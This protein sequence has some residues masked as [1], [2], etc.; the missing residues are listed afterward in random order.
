[1]PVAKT[2][3][4]MP[5]QGKPF[6]E[7]KRMYVYVI[8]KTGAKKV[9]WYTEQEYARMYNNENT[10]VKDIM[11]FNACH[12][13]GFDTHGYITI[14]KGDQDYIKEWADEHRD[15]IRYNLTFL[16]YMPSRFDLPENIPANITPIRL[17]WSQV[18]NHDV[19]MRPHDEVESM[20]RS[21][22]IDATA[23]GE[24]Q[25]NIGEWLTKNLFIIKKTSKNSYYGE[26]HLYVM[27]DNENNIYMW[28]TGAKNFSVKSQINLKMKVKAHTPYEN[29]EA[30]VVW[31][32]KEV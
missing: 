17:D 14:F 23:M 11:D 3:A 4:K 19:Y 29:H 24:Y 15:V 9:R 10:L 26:K 18:C 2:Y 13:F 31:Y 16:N 12:A 1:M 32:C 27:K 20:V 25:G 6:M 21:L 5:Q 8:S 22:I 7:N 28:E 30:T